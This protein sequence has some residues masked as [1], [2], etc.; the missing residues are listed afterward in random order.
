MNPVNPPK[1]GFF[2]KP[3]FVSP[4]TTSFP[5]GRSVDTQTDTTEPVNDVQY[6]ERKKGKRIVMIEFS[7]GQEG[8]PPIVKS[9][10]RL[11]SY[12]LIGCLI[13]RSVD[14]QTNGCVMYSETSERQKKRQIK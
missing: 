7:F 14:K 2:S 10:L 8:L 3:K 5:L 13:G 4:Q 11:E 9:P 1:G 12:W 6:E